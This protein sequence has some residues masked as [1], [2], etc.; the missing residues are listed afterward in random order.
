M[1]KKKIETLGIFGD[2]Y[3]ADYHGHRIQ[4]PDQKY[5]DKAWVNMFKNDYTVSVYAKSGSSIY[6]SY[7]LFMENHMKHDNIIFIVSGHARYHD[8]FLNES[9]TASNLAHCEMQLKNDLSAVLSQREIDRLIAFNHYYKFLQDDS[10][11]MEIARLMVDEVKRTR[12][13][14]ILVP[15][16]YGV[17]NSLFN[18]KTYLS[19]YYH[20]QFESLSSK[21]LEWSKV[22]EI[23]CYC[24]LTPEYN[25]LLYEKMKEALVEGEWTTHTIPLIKHER[26]FDWYFRLRET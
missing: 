21:V 25:Q 18:K 4:D 8:C 3:A 15:M 14:A 12:P 19:E 1:K 13:D 5:V 24:H 16:E 17:S 9:M 6:Y 11:D 22:E 23:G 26:E 7:K 2:S 20:I 10:I